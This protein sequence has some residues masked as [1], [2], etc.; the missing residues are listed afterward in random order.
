MTGLRPDVTHIYDLKT[1]FRDVIPNAVTLSQTFKN[2]G[3]YV[4]RVGKIYHYGNPGDIGTP[5][6]DDPA[7]WNDAINPAGR[8]K[9]SLE[10]D[11]VN[12]TPQRGLG[13]AMAFLADKQGMD[14]EHT[15]GKVASETIKL[16]E[17]HQKKPFFIACGFYKP[18]TPWIAP[19]KYFDLYPIERITVPTV[20]SNDVK[21]VPKEALSSTIPWPAFG[22]NEQQSRECVQAY[23]AAISFVDAQIGRVLDA[24]DRLNLWDNTV[25]V[26]W[27]DHGYHLGDHGLWMKR[28]LFENSARVPLVM[29]APGAKGRGKSCSRPVELLDLY[30]TLADIA[31]LSAPK[32][33]AGKTLRPLLE[34]PNAKWDKPAFTQVWRNGFSGHSVRTEQFRYTEWD[35]GKQGAELY[36]YDADPREQHNR[37]NDPKY[38]R[39]TSQLREVL[40]ANWHNEYRP[41]VE[42]KKKNGKAKKQNV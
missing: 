35:N 19:R 41:A 15:D 30:P 3:Y 10:P 5:G 31:G 37:V 33:L 7:S 6:L 17:E 34:N 8:D 23:Y 22:V 13:S 4:A 24:M 18:H 28:S 11:L 12:F 36:D 39:T 42:G 38:A 16:L 2:N 27:S 20:T 21:D 1:H 9:T 32:N 40:R 29:V 26:F 14:E 25:V